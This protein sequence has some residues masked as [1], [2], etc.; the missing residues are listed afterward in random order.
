MS[1]QTSF[2]F[3]VPPCRPDD[4]RETRTSQPSPSAWLC[5]YVT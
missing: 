1:A 3:I 2:D 5:R 4:P